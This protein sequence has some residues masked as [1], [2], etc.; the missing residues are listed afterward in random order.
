MLIKISRKYLQVFTKVLLNMV[1]TCNI[2]RSKENKH[3]HERIGTEVPCVV[4]CHFMLILTYACVWM[5]MMIYHGHDNDDGMGFDLTRRES[6]RGRW[7]IYYYSN[8]YR[9]YSVDIAPCLSLLS[10]VAKDNSKLT[11]V[12]LYIYN[13]YI[14]VLA[15]VQL[16]VQSLF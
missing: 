4:V 16:P 12:L 5:L 1:T 14:Y 3:F 10:Y 7:Y 2:K 6:R 8:T 13:A 11:Y 9:Q 15:F